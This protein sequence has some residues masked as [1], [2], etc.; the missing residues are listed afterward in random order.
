[1]HFFAKL[2]RFEATKFISGRFWKKF[3]LHPIIQPPV[4]SEVD[5]NVLMLAPMDNYIK[6]V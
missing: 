1:M 2:D 4:T 6:L 5:S 3:S